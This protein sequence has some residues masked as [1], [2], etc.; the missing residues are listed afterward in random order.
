MNRPIQICH[1]MCF[2]CKICLPE[3]PTARRDSNL[4]LRI[5]PHTR[6]QYGTLDRH[7]HE[8]GTRPKSSMCCPGSG[9][10]E[11]AFHDVARSRLGR[12]C[13]NTRDPQI[14]F[15]SQSGSVHAG[16]NPTLAGVR[17]DS[18]AWPRIC[19]PVAV[20]QPSNK[21]NGAAGW[22]CM[23]PSCTANCSAAVSR[24]QSCS[25][26]Y[27]RPPS[28]TFLLLSLVYAGVVEVYAGTDSLTGYTCEWQDNGYIYSCC[29]QQAAS[30]V[31]RTR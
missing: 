29:R 26:Q 8:P 12:N 13:H 14:P 4:R 31:D 5:C 2:I 30:G 18:L 9:G 11:F 25:A 23:E 10:L 6:L 3:N 15:T 16:V 19:N 7:S 17:R 21:L 1:C 24:R 28:L 20:N 22:A 27:P